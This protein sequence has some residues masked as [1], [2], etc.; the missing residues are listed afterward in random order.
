MSTLPAIFVAHGAP[1]LLDDPQWVAQLAAWGAAL[2]R[3]ECILVVCAHYEHRPMAIGATRTVPLYYDFGGFPQRY[4][5]QRYPA[6]GAPALAERV[7]ALAVGAGFSTIDEP[8]RGLDHGAYVPLVAM[9]PDADVPVLQVSL[10][11]L[12]P[13]ELVRMGRML[14]PLREEGVLIMGSGFLTHN[15]RMFTGYD[16]PPPAWARDFDDW[17]AAVLLAGDLD[18]LADFEARAPSARLAHPRTE[19]FVPVIVAAAAAQGAPVSFPITGWKWGPF[20][21]RSVQL[22]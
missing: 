4:Y 2:P 1:P 17:V 11:S 8:D 16:T 5:Q 7:R 13:P 15:L 12:S 14:A 6:P 9:Y 10:P 21:K 19:H 20:S 22:G 18:A 3:P